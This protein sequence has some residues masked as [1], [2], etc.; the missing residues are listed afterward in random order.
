MLSRPRP[1]RED[2]VAT[3][4][5]NLDI[6]GLQRFSDTLR[7]NGGRIHRVV[8]PESPVVVVNVVV[9]IFRVDPDRQLDLV[10]YYIRHKC[11]ILI[12]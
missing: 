7:S 8:N 11:F 5:G 9:R 2:L 12:S 3:P 4:T 1:G 6:L 10:L